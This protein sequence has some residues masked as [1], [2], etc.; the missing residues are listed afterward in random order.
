MSENYEQLEKA[1]GRLKK[2][3]L[4]LQKKEL[5]KQSMLTKIRNAENKSL[6]NQEES[7]LYPSL[8]KLRNYINKLARAVEPSVVLRTR[9]KEH[10]LSF[11]ERTSLGSIFAWKFARNWQKG[12]ATLLI[13]LISFATFTVYVADIPVT[14]AARNTSFQ[15]V[16]GDVEVIRGGKF[17]DAYSEMT[18]EQGD[19]VVTGD[20]GIAVIRYIDDSISRL[21]PQSE[22]KI[23]KLYQ[24][25][26][27]GTNTEI[28]VELNYGRVWSQVVNL[29]GDESSFNV[30]SDDITT[31]VSDKASFDIQN[32]EDD[33]NVE[34]AVFDNKV[35]VV[36]PDI[37]Q[38]KTQLLLEG[39]S[40]EV[41][42]SSPKAEKIDLNTNEDELW[43]Q[44]NKAKDEEYKEEVEQEAADALK[45]EAGALPEDPLY[46]AKMLNETTKLLITTDETD[47]N[48]LKADIA[49]NRLLEA[50]VLF[51][52]GNTEGAQNL[53]N[54]FNS[55]IEELS[56][57]VEN[58]DELQSYIAE[59]FVEET[60]DLVV[61]LP[62]SRLYPIKEALRDAELTLVITSEEK[63][64]IIL[65]QASE[66]I[67]EAKDLIED[68]KEE[69][70]ANVLEEVQEGV[71]EVAIEDEGEVGEEL[72]DAQ[73]DTLASA[74]VLQE[75]IEEEDVSNEIKQLI[76]V[77]Q[78]VLEDDLKDSVADHEPE[79]SDET[80]EKADTILED[81][82]DELI[83]EEVLVT[84]SDFAVIL[85]VDDT[86]VQLR[87][88][89][90]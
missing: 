11:A 28:E 82:V 55:I 76:E 57:S 63:Q 23:H 32:T 48:K 4:D 35:E 13:A 22:L 60:K 75:A 43:V 26:E 3:T 33:S 61:I 2:P 8:L 68:D 67:I 84:E 90:K 69:L 59:L 36:L 45:E 53:L 24:D 38:D 79:V 39:Y 64:E 65:E 18:L 42:K 51:T 30:V 31:T 5:M 66:K 16:F 44:I 80:L 9:I 41:D 46:S 71:V 37:K 86:T 49:I 78:E 89:P 74:M 34:V 12:L 21:S 7:Y 85:S 81:P 47:K 20:N 62:D 70:A 54:E 19:V 17:L 10:V 73:V 72:I 52:E 87:A 1:L 6:A 27:Q 83:H 25:E 15:E 77:S 56:Y 58:S 50:S 40:L 14:K 29:V 88:M